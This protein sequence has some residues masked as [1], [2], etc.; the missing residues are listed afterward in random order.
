MSET[1][2]VGDSRND[3]AMLSEAGLSLAVSNASEEL[4]K[5]A[6]I[7]ISSNEEHSAEYILK[8]FL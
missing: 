8:N 3:I 7:V 5:H 4:K 6:D 1:I 2:A